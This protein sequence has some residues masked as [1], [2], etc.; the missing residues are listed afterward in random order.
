MVKQLKKGREHLKTAY[1]SLV[2]M[3]C[4]TLISLQPV[5]ADTIWDRFSKIMKDVYGQLVGISTIVAVVSV[6]GLLLLV[7]LEISLGWNYFKLLL[8]TV[9]R[10]I[11]VQMYP[12]A[13]LGILQI[14][15]LVTICRSLANTS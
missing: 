9:E 6:V 7:I 14:A 4:V 11:V 1:W 13:L 2:G 3:A 5:M 15:A 10:Y 8:E 12:T